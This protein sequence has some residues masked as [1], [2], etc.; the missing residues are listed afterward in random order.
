MK[1]Y[2]AAIALICL[3]LNSCKKHQ[4]QPPVPI[5]KMG[6]VLVDIQLA[7][8]YSLGLG[9]D[10]TRSRFSKNYDS[11]EVFY[12][13]ILKHHNLS[14]AKFNEAMA[15]YQERPKQEDS[16]LSLV[17]DNLHVQQTEFHI[18]DEEE[19]KTDNKVR[20]ETDSLNSK[21]KAARPSSPDMD[22]HF[23][24]AHR[25]SVLKTQL[26]KPPV[27]EAPSNE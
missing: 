25:D 6:K 9:P 22:A 16:L 17:L 20:L 5:D 11:L 15:W 14:F 21:S 18:P 10:S 23:D 26:P 1:F 27:L 12:S 4:E 3:S 7:E 24:K 19:K 2:F 13:S 8:T